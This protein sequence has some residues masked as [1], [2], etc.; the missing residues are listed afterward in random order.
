M[1]VGDGD[2]GLRRE[3]RGREESGWFLWAVDHGDDC[4]ITK[5]VDGGTLYICVLSGSDEERRGEGPTQPCCIRTNM[6][7]REEGFDDTQKGQS[8]SSK[9][10]YSTSCVVAKPFTFVICWRKFMN[11]HNNN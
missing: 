1:G 5:V 9:M 2:G 4:R 3:G 8:F 7:R 6:K 10:T 11:N